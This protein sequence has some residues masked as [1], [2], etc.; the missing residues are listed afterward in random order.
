MGGGKA[1]DG[2][3]VWWKC[4]GREKIFCHKEREQRLSLH[5]RLSLS[6]C[7]FVSMMPWVVWRASGSHGIT[8]HAC[9]FWNLT[10]DAVNDLS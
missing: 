2:E 9:W 10:A 1:V 8:P 5:S 4:R 6:C 3:V 7:L